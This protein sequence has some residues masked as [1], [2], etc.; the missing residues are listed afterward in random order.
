MPAVFGMPDPALRR[1]HC[2]KGNELHAEFVQK[3]ENHEGISVVLA[4]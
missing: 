2:K 4:F 1:T 3:R